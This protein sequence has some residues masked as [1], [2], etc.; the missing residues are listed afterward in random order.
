MFFTQQYIR[1]FPCVDTHFTNYIFNS[2]IILSHVY[3]MYL[4]IHLLWNINVVDYPIMHIFAY[5]A[6]SPFF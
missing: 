1:A 2:Y 5:K 3:M 6:F 4:P